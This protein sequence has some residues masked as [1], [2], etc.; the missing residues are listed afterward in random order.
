MASLGSGY[1]GAQ[2][3]SFISACAPAPAPAPTAAPAPAVPGN[4]G[5]TATATTTTATATAAAAAA[6]RAGTGQVADADD[7]LRRIERGLA[8]RRAERALASALSCASRP[9]QAPWRDTCHVNNPF[10]HAGWMA[11]WD[12]GVGEGWEADGL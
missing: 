11:A 3:A 2:V 5:F 10:A 9:E 1:V 7:A 12:R 4:D 6:R 8:A